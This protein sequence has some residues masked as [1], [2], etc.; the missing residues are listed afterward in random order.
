MG[1]GAGAEGDKAFRSLNGLMALLSE[2]H[3]R[4]TLVYTILFSALF[5]GSVW[6]VHVVIFVCERQIQCLD[7]LL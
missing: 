1:G 5:I 4:K 6:F 2:T 3:Y 7:F